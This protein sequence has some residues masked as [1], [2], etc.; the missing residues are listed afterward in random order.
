MCPWRH[1]HTREPH[2][3]YTHTE[4]HTHVHILRHSAHTDKSVDTYTHSVHTPRAHTQ[5]CRHIH[6]WVCGV[7]RKSQL[8]S[9]LL[10]WT[11]S[12][13]YPPQASRV[14]PWLCTISL[15]IL[16]L[17]RSGQSSPEPCPG[18]SGHLPTPS[19]PGPPL[20]PRTT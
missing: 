20:G 4:V 15:P 3:T 6:V 2:H 12:W 17:T 11:V 9:R 7:F 1:E 19:I 5:V 14:E 13:P 8:P 18:S 16:V 10:V